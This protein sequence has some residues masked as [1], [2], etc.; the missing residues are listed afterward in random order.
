MVI[1]PQ[2][3]VRPGERGPQEIFL[4]TSADIGVIGGAAG[5]G[6][7][8]VLEVEPLRHIN[9]PRFSAVIFRRTYPQITNEGGPWAESYEIYPHVGGVPR[10]SGNPPL[11]WTFPSGATV[12]FAHMQHEKDRL[13]WKSAQNPL[14]CFDQL[15][16]F[17]EAQFFYMLSR[18]RSMSGVRPYF[19]ATCNPDPDSFLADL[20][21]WWID[22]REEIPGPDGRPVENPG[23]G[24]PIKERSGVLRWFVRNGDDLVWASRPE[25]LR[26]RFPKL[27]PRSFTFVPATLEDNPILDLGDPDYRANLMALPLVERLR[28]LGGNWKVRPMAGLVFNRAW[29]KITEAVPAGAWRRIRYWD[30]AGTPEELATSGTAGSAGVRLFIANGQVFIEDVI[31]GRW[32]SAE[33]ERVIRQTA[34]LDGPYVEQWVE[35]EPG[36][37]GKESAQNTVVNLGGFAV[38]VDRVSGSDGDKVR[39]AYPLSAQAEHGN[40]YLVKGEWN[41]LFLQQAH[42]FPKGIIDAVDAAN[43]AYNKATLTSG[44]LGTWPST[45][46]FTPG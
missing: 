23:Y 39:R 27:P 45:S 1:G 7:T 44:P 3:G 41:A 19:R 6:K 20:L 8:W 24:Y 28:L 33:R 34:E 26:A 14:F 37:G 46:Q 13:S 40:V 12:R 21:E 29:F 42:R 5:G 35:Q 36:S 16:D 18:G 11:L 25:E 43:G 4:S 30:K 10:E 31:W 17:T 32:S 22:Q 15:E 9:N 2:P 38:A